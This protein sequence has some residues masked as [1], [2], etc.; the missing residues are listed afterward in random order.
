MKKKKLIAVIV[1]LA[2][3]LF[4]GIGVFSAVMIN[5]YLEEYD[6]GSAT[7]RDVVEVNL[8]IKDYVKIGESENYDYV[9][10][11]GSWSFK[12]SVMK[13]YDNTDRLGSAFLFE[14]KENNPYWVIQTDDWCF[15]FRVYYISKGVIED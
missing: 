6:T 1:S 15:F 3:L 7:F 9:L 8:D 11:K 12:S 4:V 2:V 14:D 13:D 10:A 5:R